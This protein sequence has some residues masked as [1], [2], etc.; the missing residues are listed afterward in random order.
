MSNVNEF[1]I[2]RSVTHTRNILKNVYMWMTI[3]LAITG[4]VAYGLSQNAAFMQSLIHSPAVFVIWIAQLATVFFL[5]AFV[6]KMSPTVATIVFALYAVLNG[7]TFSTIFLRYDLGSIATTFFIT[8]GTFAA[9]SVYGLTTKR[10]LSKI[11]NYLLMGL[12][13]VII[14]SVVNFFLNSSVI[15]YIISFVGVLV[16]VGLTA[17]DTQKIK[18][19][20]DAHGDSIGEADYIRLSIQGALSLYLDFINLFIF[21]LRLLGGRR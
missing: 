5:S 8:A 19:M 7:V 12:I 14:A 20:S 17:W 3:A 6:W 4:V 2:P 15:Q 11:G 21:L 18:K 13:G 1:S 16:F 10:D 9:M